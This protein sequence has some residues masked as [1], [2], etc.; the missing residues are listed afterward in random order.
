[1][2]KM[3]VTCFTDIGG[4]S[5]REKK[6]GH[7]KVQ[8]VLDEYLEIGKILIKQNSGSYVKNIG[9]CH[10]ATFDYIES[11]LGFA[12]QFQ[13]YYYKQPVQ[14]VDPVLVRVTLCLGLVEPKDGDVFGPGVIRAAR[15]ATV[16]PP[17]FITMN[18]NLKQK[19]WKIWDRRAA[20]RYCKSIGKCKLKGIGQREELFQFNWHGFA[21]DHPELTLAGRVFECLK[22][23]EIEFSNVDLQDLAPPGEIIW[24]VVPRK[25]VTAIHRA[26]MEIIRILWP[27]GREVHLLVANCG[28]VINLE[29]DRVSKFVKEIR[30]HALSRGLGPIKVSFLKDY[31]ASG[32]PRQENVLKWFHTITASLNVQHLIDINQKDYSDDVQE[33][34]RKDPALDFLRP[35]LTCAAAVH[36]AEE[37]QKSYPR[38]KTIV[39]GGADE[40][41]QWDYVYKV[42]PPNSLGGILN[43]VL[44]VSKKR[45]PAHTARQTSEWP[46]WSST[47]ELLEDIKKTNA[48]KWIFQ[49]FVQLPLFPLPYVP[50]GAAG[51][52]KPVTAKD[53][54]NEFATPRQIDI[55]KLV[56]SAWPIL[57]PLRAT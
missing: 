57:K 26:Q 22:E 43:P 30:K 17:S 53:W 23:A 25:L 3:Q 39:V 20:K 50:A 28:A 21:E 36:L 47:R 6:L 35:M 34:I 31:F 27:L 56:E 12:T 40:S 13:Q 5:L 48:A 18:K 4:Y 8:R 2:T 19:L 29:Q 49:L 51:S 42:A 38:A 33:K 15:Q 32:D 10:M 55:Q 11:A 24:P 46:S 16:T 7:V 45:G 41:I 37:M 44:K 1:M 14:G 9:D 54:G 52:K